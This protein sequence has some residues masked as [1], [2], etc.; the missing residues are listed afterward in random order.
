MRTK[1]FVEKLS[2][3]D[4]LL[5]YFNNLFKPMGKDESIEDYETRVKTGIDEITSYCE[6]N[7]PA[8]KLSFSDI[9]NDVV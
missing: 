3:D 8:I 7:Y 9:E 1:D 4:T 6:D 2:T 5:T